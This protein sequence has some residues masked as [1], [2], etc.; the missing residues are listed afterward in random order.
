MWRFRDEN[1]DIRFLLEGIDVFRTPSD[2]LPEILRERGHDVVESDCGFEEVTDLSVRL[3]NNSSFEYLVDEEGDA[4]Y[5]DYV[6][7]FDK[8]FAST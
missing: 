1:A 5:Y 3:A 7:V 8:N 2:D 4:L 6:L